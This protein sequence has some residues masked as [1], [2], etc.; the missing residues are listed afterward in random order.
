[1]IIITRILEFS[2]NHF[3]PY[4][5]CSHFQPFFSANVLSGRKNFILVW[6]WS[7]RLMGPP[8]ALYIFFGSWLHLIS[9]GRFFFLFKF[10]PTNKRKNQKPKITYWESV[11]RDY[12]KNDTI[13]A[14]K[15][16]KIWMPEK[17]SFSMTIGIL[18]SK[19]LEWKF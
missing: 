12:Q 15:Y 4:L 10:D 11:Y 14:W 9:G 16:R 3:D 1:M 6:P 5:G 2:I 7:W 13:L 18:E 19:F 17:S 8:T